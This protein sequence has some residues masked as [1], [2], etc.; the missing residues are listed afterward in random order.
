[1][2]LT[3]K[4]Y[5]NT[6]TAGIGK[7]IPDLIRQYDFSEDNGSL[8]YLTKSS[9]VYSSA[10]EGN[11]I[12]LNSYMNYDLSKTKFN[13]SKEIE[14]INDLIKAYE[15]ARIN[16]LNKDNFCTSHKILSKNLLIKSKRGTYRFEAVGIFGKSGL[17]YMAVEPEFVK[18]EMQKFFAAAEELLLSE[19]NEVEVFYFA[20]L[21]H[22][23]F[24]H[25]HPFMDRNGRAARLLEKWFLAEKLGEKFWKIPSEEYYKTHQSQY[26]KAIDLGVNFY[27]LD[28]S[29]CMEFLEMLPSCLK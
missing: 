11:S 16:N 3:D 5:L 19:L 9:A 20:S 13:N 17:S 23:R 10:I 24:V 18:G 15:F 26:Y 29:N 14:Q 25:I 22:L 27:E 8:D 2:N 1:M 6:Y 4:R 12:N 21:L 7:Q 28:Y